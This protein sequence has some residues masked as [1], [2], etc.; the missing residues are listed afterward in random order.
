MN[1]VDFDEVVAE[2]AA[3]IGYGEDEETVKNFCRQWIWGAKK[4]MSVSDNTIQV[5]QITAKNLLLPK[6]KNFKKLEEIA[7]FD[8]SG[9]YLPHVFHQ[10]TSRI[11]PNVDQ[12]SYSVVL[13]EGEDDEETVTY[14][15][16]I[17]LSEN[18]NSFVIGTNGTQVDYALVRYWPLPLDK[19]G[20][21]E[22]YEH[23]VDA[24]KAYCRYQWSQRK[25]E[26]Q[27]EIAQNRQ[28]WKEE[29][30]WAKATTKSLDFSNEVRKRIGA[31]T[32]RMIPNF[33]RSQF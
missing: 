5:C 16:P 2:C 30:D 24:C 10:G 26:N 3:I 21:P 22:I 11:Y 32:N 4:K 27:S 18:K 8:S 31:I 20:L 12:F 13:N 17:D 7:L 25:N 28:T 6:P 15:L 23:E 33:N 14:Y 29:C 9:N 19:N 1:F